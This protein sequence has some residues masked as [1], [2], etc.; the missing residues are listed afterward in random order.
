MAGDVAL[1][2]KHRVL[3]ITGRS[4]WGLQSV[5]CGVSFR[6]LAWALCALLMLSAAKAG[7]A[8]GPGGAADAVFE[9]LNQKNGLPAPVVQALAQDSS[10][11]LW[12]ATEDGISRWD[13]YHFRN[14]AMQLGVAGALPEN[15]VFSLYS[16]PLGRFWIGTKSRGVVRYDPALDKFETFLPSG[17]EHTY[18]AIYSLVSD[19]RRGL[20]VG[21]RGG[22]DHLD[23]DTKVFTHVSMEGADKKPLPQGSVQALVRDDDGRVWAGTTKGLFR[24]DRNGQHFTLMPVFGDKVVRVWSLLRDHGG[25]LW[26]GATLGAYVLEPGSDVA[27]QVQE[28][29]QDGS[30]LDAQGVDTIAEAAP[31]VVWLGT[32]ANGI[33]SVDETTLETHR[34]LHDAEFATSLADDNV[35]ALHADAAGS[36]WVG[37]MRGVSRS[38]HVGV[39][40]QTFYGGARREGAGGVARGAGRISDSDVT[41]VL[42]TKDG[43]I[44]VGLNVKGVEVFDTT[45]AKISALLPSSPKKKSLL[46][47]GQV[48]GF[49]AGPDGSVYFGGAQWVMRADHNGQHLTALPFRDEDGKKSV[50][51]GVHTLLSDAGSLWIGSQDGLWKQDVSGDAAGRHTPLP[52]LI[53]LTRIQITGLARGVGNDLW[54]GTATELLRYD[55]V[56]GAVETIAVD[57]SNG[58]ALPAAVTSLMVD[59]TGRLWVTTFGGGVCVMEGRDGKG[60]PRFRRLMKGLPNANTD[61][62]RQARD[63]SVWVSTDDG[64]AVIDPKTFAITPLRQP[65]GVAIQDYWVDAG[66]V[67]EDGRLM[68]GGN[69]GLTI[70]QPERVKRWAYVPQV[71]V[72]DVMIG[73]KTVASERFNDASSGPLEI[74]HDANS[75]AVEFAALDYTAPELNL[76]AYRLVGFDRDWVTTDAAHRTA[77]YTNLPPGNYT[78]ELKG[79]NRDGVWGEVRRVAIRVVPAW[80]QTM[81]AR[82]AALL[83]F[84]GVLFLGFRA[85]TAYLRA[86]QRVLERKVAARTAELQKMTVELEKSHRMLEESH[87]KLEEIAYSDSLTGLP[88]RRMFQDCFH[89]LL[90][91]KRREKSGF[92]LMVF[93]LDKFKEINDGHGHDAGDAWLKEVARRLSP[94]VRQSDCFARL[95]GDEFAILLA[96]R[97]SDEGIAQVCQTIESS[98]AGPLLLGGL[99]LQS[100]LS[101]G[102][103]VYP[104][105]GESE[106]ELYK[107]ADL[108]LYAVKRVGG[109]GWRRFERERVEG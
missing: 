73:D 57:A 30:P 65:D 8:Q 69:G 51:H 55:V 20:W 41:A 35:V 23:T 104:E 79:S 32:Y 11:F 13:G 36:V 76:Y 67:S 81:W 94:I 14:Y 59:R 64:L 4:R 12:V 90:G 93:D 75:V 24:S 108:A 31:G 6:L 46:P 45:G 77:R 43:R 101:I 84:V 60:L 49:A 74:K 99:M 82:F 63:G 86:R 22:L 83:L 56:T 54:V 16:D 10:G 70:V 19:G 1:R 87:K 3:Q 33:V 72:T 66:A 48:T 109:N 97:V 106:D 15:N 103:A 61:A 28:A 47:A 25:R 5:R 44:W 107:S 17:K 96:E 39:S 62:V 105:D 21:T 38:D 88:N 52:V 29:G 95:G 2:L 42:P 50:G 80:Y 34:I 18:K 89:R 85:S 91:L 40:I 27:R 9:H 37:T 53:P 78:L 102:V 100:T 92:V 7:L 71:V 98:F 26:I 68:F 58:S